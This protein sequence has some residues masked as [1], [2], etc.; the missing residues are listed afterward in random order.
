MEPTC[1]QRRAHH[2][3]AANGQ[4]RKWPLV[5]SNNAVQT[6]FKSSGIERSGVR[7]IHSGNPRPSRQQ[8]AAPRPDPATAGDGN[9]SCDERGRIRLNGHRMH[10]VGSPGDEWSPYSWKPITLPRPCHGSRRRPFPGA[11]DRVKG[12]TAAARPACECVPRHRC[13]GSPKGTGE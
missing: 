4:P 6:Q 1:C 8:F 10:A 3:L 7:Q 11:A 5:S 13:A 12:S 9:V 2:G